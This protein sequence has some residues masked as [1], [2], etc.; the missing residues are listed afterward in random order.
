MEY[1]RGLIM[2]NFEKYFKDPRTAAETI[3]RILFGQLNICDSMCRFSSDE[4]CTD[5]VHDDY[6]CC[7]G[8]RYWLEQECKDE[9]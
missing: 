5:Q 2:N 1:R 4:S 6:D 8:I 7:D 9:N 3:E